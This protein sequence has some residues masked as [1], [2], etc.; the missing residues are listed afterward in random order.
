MRAQCINNQYIFFSTQPIHIE[1]T[2]AFL[3]AIK[4]THRD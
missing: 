2:D 3:H 4:C 1:R